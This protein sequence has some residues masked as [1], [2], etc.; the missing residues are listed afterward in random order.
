[1]GSIMRKI[2]F[3]ILISLVSKSQA[4]K[5]DL[6]VSKLESSLK[7]FA[8]KLSRSFAEKNEKVF[9]GIVL[10]KAAFKK[11]SNNPQHEDIQ[12]LN[13]HYKV[14]RDE[15]ISDFRQI[16]A[17]DGK[18]GSFSTFEAISFSYRKGSL[19]KEVKYCESLSLQSEIGGN[20]GVGTIFVITGRIYSENGEWKIGER[21]KSILGFQADFGSNPNKIRLR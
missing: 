1:M 16:V 15:I 19:W 4:N 2:I 8:E 6:D 13:A 5:K 10:S 18:L 17:P 20:F 21:F 9:S 12:V 11:L 3:I 7:N 14:F